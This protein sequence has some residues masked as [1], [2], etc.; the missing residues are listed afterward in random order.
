MTAFNTN[1]QWAEEVRKLLLTE[2]RLGLPTA[3]K[4]SKHLSL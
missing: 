3:F 1:P 4:K 2:D